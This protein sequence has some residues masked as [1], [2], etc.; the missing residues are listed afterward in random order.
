MVE[1][2][3]TP[4][5]LEFFSELA[6]ENALIIR[7]AGG[8]SNLRT[9]VHQHIPQVRILGYRYK[10]VAHLHLHSKSPLIFW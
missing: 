3:H 4:F 1:G 8:C 2:K 7:P 5:I 10:G 6:D 9:D